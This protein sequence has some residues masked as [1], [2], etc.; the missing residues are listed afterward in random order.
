MRARTRQLRAVTRLAIP[1]R[2]RR[3]IHEAG[4]AV[5]AEVLGYFWRDMRFVSCEEAAVTA[6]MRGDG[7]VRWSTLA[8][9]ERAIIY[10]LGPQAEWAQGII[11]P[12]VVAGW[13]EDKRQISMHIGDYRERAYCKLRVMGI[14]SKHMVRIRKLAARFDRVGFLPGARYDQPKRIARQNP[15]RRKVRRRAY[16]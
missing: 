16:V 10:W 9:L 6:F 1:S 2:R 15:G 12:R 7:D 4:H 8:A 13:D 3:A 5:A 11:W 14:L